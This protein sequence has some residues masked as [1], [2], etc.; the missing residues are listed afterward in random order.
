MLRRARRGIALLLVACGLLAA[1]TTANAA[2]LPRLADLETQT[3]AL[4][5]F[6]QLSTHCAASTAV[7]DTALAYSGSTSLR[8]HTGNDATC[9]GP[10]ARAIFRANSPYNLVEGDDL[11]F[12]AAIY[13]PAGFYAA[14]TG[15]TDLLRLDSYVRDDSTSTSFADRAE[16]NFAS[17]GNDSLYVRAARGSTSRVLIGPISPSA[18]AEG[19]WNWVEVHADL[20]STS[21]VAYTELKINGR[22]MGA[23]KTAN[24]FAG[25]APLNRLRCGIVSTESGGSGDLTA[26]VDRASINHSERGPNTPAP[27]PPPTPEPPPPATEDPVSLWRLN[28]ASGS[29]AA[30]AMGVAPGTYL[31]GPTLGVPGIVGDGVDGAASFDG[32]DDYVAISPTA[33]LNM[34]AGLTLEAWAKADSLRGSVIRRNNSYE[35]R[36]QS[37]GSVLFRVWIGG[38]TRSLR[39][40]A[41]TVSAGEVHHLVGTYDGANMMIYVDGSQV[42]SMPQTGAMTHN[43]NTLYIGRNDYSDTYFDGVI[44]EAAI[45]SGALSAAT[46]GDRFENG[47]PSAEALRQASDSSATAAFAA[48]NPTAG[49]EPEDE[50]SREPPEVD[51]EPTAEAGEEDGLTLAELLAWYYSIYVMP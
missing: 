13:L 39:S 38:T 11:W 51:P 48:D 17:W 40:A 31:N 27:P 46:V 30:D 43:G 44:D 32:V 21:G 15:Y 4:L 35:L 6:D 25:A 7:R 18:L 34:K 8:V 42:T 49:S 45:Y 1:V 9:S 47:R 37:D 23:S 16:I 5:N 14:H 29:R 12:G 24:L 2:V 19:S 26:Y 28:E 33:P 50:G 22:S 41:N 20:S 10:Y 3:T 36:A